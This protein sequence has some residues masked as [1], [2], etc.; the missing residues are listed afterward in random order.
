MYSRKLT[1]PSVPVPPATSDTSA[2]VSDIQQRLERLD[3]TDANYQRL[4]LGLLSHQ[5]LRKYIQSLQEHDLKGFV[6]LLDKAS[7]VDNGIR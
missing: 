1:H 7:E 6:E 4:L 5:G 3:P 2:S